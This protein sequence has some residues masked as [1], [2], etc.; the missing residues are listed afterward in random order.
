MPTFRNRNS[1][2]VVQ[3]DDDPSHLSGLARWERVEEGPSAPAAPPSE[4]TE[5]VTVPETT[6]AESEWTQVGEVT[7]DVAADVAAGEPDAPALPAADADR[8]EWVAYAKAQGKTD[9][10]LKGKKVETI[11]GWFVED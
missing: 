2:Q 5:P 4:V 7:A 10:E 1:G 11:R 6:P 3:V 8:A 9:A